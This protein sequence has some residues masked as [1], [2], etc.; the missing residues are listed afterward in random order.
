[1][2]PGGLSLCQPCVRGQGVYMVQG[3][4]FVNRR[5]RGRRGGGVRLASRNARG[6]RHAQKSLWA[7]EETTKHCW[8]AR[9]LTR[10]AERRLNF[11]RF[12][13]GKGRWK[14][15]VRV[16]PAGHGAAAAVG[17]EK[18][19]ER[20]SLKS[21]RRHTVP[22]RY[23]LSKDACGIP[24][25]ARRHTISA[26]SAFCALSPRCSVPVLT[27]F[28][29]R[30]ALHCLPAPPPTTAA[31]PFSILGSQNH[32]TAPDFTTISSPV[33][34][35]PQPP[36]PATLYTFSL[37]VAPVVRFPVMSVCLSPVSPHQF[38]SISKQNTSPVRYAPAS[39]PFNLQFP[40]FVPSLSDPRLMAR[41]LKGQQILAG[42]IYTHV[43]ILCIFLSSCYLHLRLL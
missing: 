31:L 9:P 10:E 19:N 32:S 35:A 7:G 30:T 34:R 20:Q 38:P 1:M 36:R 2:G 24:R 18:E 29:A 42:G 43:N 21:C 39:F 13:S 37:R 14:L 11:G 23:R 16:L 5:R 33:S 3:S 28:Y 6:Y 40:R 4:S 8:R 15:A 25:R 26:N 17:L 41:T 27:A 12:W 22:G